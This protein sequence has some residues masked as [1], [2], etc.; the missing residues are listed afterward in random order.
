MQKL[1]SF[2]D[3]G[4]FLITIA[5]LTLFASVVILGG[6]PHGLSATEA[7]SDIGPFLVLAG[8]IG[9]ITSAYRMYV[10]QNALWQNAA[11]HSLIVLLFGLTFLSVGIP[12]I[13]QLAGA[14]GLAYLLSKVVAQNHAM[15]G[16][17]P[18]MFRVTFMAFLGSFA[19]FALMTYKAD[20]LGALIPAVAFMG[21][22]VGMI[23]KPRPN[24]IMTPA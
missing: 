19:T 16:D 17:E 6:V 4:R 14:T 1:F 21:I 5:L 9:L 10:R 13:L 23:L 11:S 12:L 7:A 20:D 18:L 24:V 15:T 2:L 22:A 8:G 3:T